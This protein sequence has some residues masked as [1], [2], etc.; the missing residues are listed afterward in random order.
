MSDKIACFLTV[1]ASLYRTKAKSALKLPKKHQ[2]PWVQQ[3]QQRFS[4]LL[5]STIYKM[6]TLLS[7][8]HAR[9]Q[10]DYTTQHNYTLHGLLYCARHKQNPTLI[11]DSAYQRW[12]DH[13]HMYSGCKQK[14]KNKNIQRFVLEEST[15]LHYIYPRIKVTDSDSR[16]GNFAKTLHANAGMENI[17]IKMK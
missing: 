1:L 3:Q 16:Q 9:I 11:S 4:L 14:K 6:L 10:Q 5:L 8:L 13:M 12:P 7:T 17:L 15:F 2:K